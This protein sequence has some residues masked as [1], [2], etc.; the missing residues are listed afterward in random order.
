[1][2]A[3]VGLQLGH[4]DLLAVGAVLLTALGYAAGPLVL[5]RRLAD[6][7]AVGVVTASL[8]VTAV[9]WAP[10]AA[11]SVPRHMS[12]K[13]VASMLALALVCTAAAFLVFFALIAE[14]GPARATVITY[15]NPA[16]AIL[17]GVLVLGERFT[18]GIAVGF[19]LVLLGSVLA[20]RRPRQAL[21]GQGCASSDTTVALAA[22]AVP[23]VVADDSVSGWASSHSERH[24]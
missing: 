21:A 12:G 10:A 1:V 18:L 3:L 8:L 22:P 6:L 20:T 4:L 11:A 15:V 14:V 5:S 24:V 13:V 19:P 16:V 9:V 17:L 7:P 2:G 23:E